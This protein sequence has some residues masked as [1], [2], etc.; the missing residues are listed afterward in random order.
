MNLFFVYMSEGKN[1]FSIANIKLSHT[2]E[3][4]NNQG[5]LANE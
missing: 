2:I 1:V 3:V 5:W 4:S